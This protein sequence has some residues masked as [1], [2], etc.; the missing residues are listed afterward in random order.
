MVFDRCLPVRPFADTGQQSALI[1]GKTVFAAAKSAAGLCGCFLPGN[2]G[3]AIVYTPGHGFGMALSVCAPP[4]SV[5]SVRISLAAPDFAGP[6][7]TVRAHGDVCDYL[8]AVSGRRLAAFYVTV[9]SCAGAAVKRVKAFFRRIHNYFFRNSRK[10]F[11]RF[12]L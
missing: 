9:R 12:R 8:I 7:L 2:P 11:F 3:K 1:F 4:L 5:E 6:V 10:I